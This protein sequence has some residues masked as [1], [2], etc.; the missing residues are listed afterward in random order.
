M[1]TAYPCG[2]VDIAFVS[3]AIVAWSCCSSAAVD[4]FAERRYYQYRSFQ[5]VGREQPACGSPAN[6][7]AELIR[8]WSNIRPSL[9]L[10]KS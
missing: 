10:C 7:E 4:A 8:Y 6:D 1:E 9:R 2:D 3:M 5:V